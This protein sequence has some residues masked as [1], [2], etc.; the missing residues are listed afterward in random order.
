M[1]ANPDYLYFTIRWHFRE[2][3]K[4]RSQMG[5]FGMLPLH[6]VGPLRKERRFP[7]CT[8]A[9]AIRIT[10]CRHDAKPRQQHAK[11]Y[12]KATYNKCTK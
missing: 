10:T 11:H 12:T 9:Q 8:T 1:L 6:K 3:S 4:L 7:F 2:S 5:I